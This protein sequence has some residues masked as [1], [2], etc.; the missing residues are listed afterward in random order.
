M[1]QE[2][3]GGV[4]LFEEELRQTVYPWNGIMGGVVDTVCKLW[5]PPPRL[6]VS[7]WADRERVLSAESCAEP[8]RWHTDRAEYLRGMMDAFNDPAIETIV[9]MTSAQVGKTSVVENT[10]GY[11]I[12]M[13]PAPVLLVEPT[14]I[15]GQEFSKERLS[16]MLRDTKRLHE[17]VADAK[18]RD[19]ENTIM[20][21]VYPGGHLSLCGANSAAGLSSRPVRF[22]FCDEV[23]KYPQ[24]A[25][26]EG[27]PV[28]LAFKRATTFWNRKF[29]VTSTPSIAGISRIEAFFEASDKRYFFLPCP[30]CGKFQRLVWA[31]VRWDKNPDGMH[32]TESAVYVCEFCQ[33]KIVNNEKFAMLRKGEWRATAKSKGVAGYHLS[34]LYSPWVTWPQMVNNFLEAKKSPDTLQVFINSSLGE[35]WDAVGSTKISEEGLRARREK[36]AAEVPLDVCV[37]TCGVDV[38]DD[39]IESEVV[40]W[41]LDYESWN[42][43]S[44]VFRGDPSRLDVWKELDAYLQKEFMHEAG[45]KMKIACTCL[46]TGHATQEVYGFVLPREY[47]RIWAVKGSNQPGRPIVGRPTK[48]NAMRV[49]LFPIGTDTAKELIYGRLKIDTPGPSYCH[50]PLARDDEYFAQLTAEKLVPK[51]REGRLTR[52]WVAKRQRNEALD[53]RVYATAALYILNPD[54]PVLAENIRAEAEELAK[55]EEAGIQKTADGVENADDMGFDSLR[56]GKKF[57]RK[58]FTQGWR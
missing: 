58:G 43:D 17:K 2:Q 53:M 44:P 48:S 55:K 4:G 18:T 46:D 16:P 49:N 39:R 47:R 35:V 37:M 14:L 19:E 24:S 23:D 52:Q 42:I 22:V 51:F 56:K 25:G 10:T 5:A 1:E 57:R 40:G 45:I 54:L 21:K 33:R 38:Q 29:I 12:D 28:N 50:F 6:T 27:D 26:T 15:K 20:H 13:D 11:V 41:G 32:N 36:Y 3:G 34:E 8:G 9:F 30:E 31:N 7:Q